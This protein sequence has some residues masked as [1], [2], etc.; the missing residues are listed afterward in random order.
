GYSGGKTGVSANVEAARWVGQLTAGGP[1]HRRAG[2]CVRRIVG[3]NWTDW[4]DP[5]RA[6]CQS[7]FLPGR[8]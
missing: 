5:D 8:D 1:K 7:A 2:V 4:M 3:G 6:A